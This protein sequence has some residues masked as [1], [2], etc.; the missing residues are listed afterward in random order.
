MTIIIA[1]KNNDGIV[2]AASNA[3]TAGSRQAYTHANKIINLCAGW[4]IG[5]MSIGAANIKNESAETC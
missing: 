4:P 1:V 2:K 5:A 3:G